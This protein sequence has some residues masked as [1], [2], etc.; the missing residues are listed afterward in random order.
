MAQDEE[1]EEERDESL[2]LDSALR[3]LGDLLLGCGLVLHELHHPD[4]PRVSWP[5]YLEALMMW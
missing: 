2:D 1:E 4:E 5:S 3:E